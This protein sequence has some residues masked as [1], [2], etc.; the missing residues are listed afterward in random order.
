M[1]DNGSKMSTN[2]PTVMI[3]DDE[4]MVTKTLAAYLE[5]ETDLKV[6]TFQ[7]PKL[8][9]ERLNQKPVDLVISDFL[10]PDMDGLQFI[11]RAQ[12]L[13]PD[14]AC[15][16]LTG[17][18]DKENAIKAVNEVRLFQYVEKPWENEH[19]KLIIRNAIESKSLRETLQLKIRE[20][21][22]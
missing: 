5:L 6:L 3:V 2:I 1:R 22:Q 11:A 20:L 8:A 16:L 13:Y 14:L 7:S 4:E 21:D 12:Q 9:L 17:Y 18:A 15:I 19:I 10:M